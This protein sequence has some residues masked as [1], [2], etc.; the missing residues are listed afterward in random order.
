[1]TIEGWQDE[2]GRRND[3]LQVGCHGDELSCFVGQQTQNDHQPIWSGVF[4]YTG[5]RLEEPFGTNQ[6]V[7]RGC[8]VDAPLTPELTLVA[9]VRKGFARIWI[10]EPS[11]RQKQ[12]A[13]PTNRLGIPVREGFR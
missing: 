2:R 10:T 5:S 1:M 11:I 13:G 12:A 6:H 4:R 7:D 9:A 3:I 8:D